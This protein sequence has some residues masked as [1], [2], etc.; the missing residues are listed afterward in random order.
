MSEP[1]TSPTWVHRPQAGPIAWGTAVLVA[2][3]VPLLS[4]FVLLV[5]IAVTPGGDNRLPTVFS[6][7]LWLVV[8]ALMAWQGS[9]RVSRGVGVGLLGGAVASLV[10]AVVASYGGWR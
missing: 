5:L 6:P 1:R 2:P 10:L 8:G 3:A 4:V 7:V 9:G